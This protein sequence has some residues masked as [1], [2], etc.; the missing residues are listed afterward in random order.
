MELLCRL[1]LKTDQGPWSDLVNV[2]SDRM[3]YAGLRTADTDVEIGVAVIRAMVKSGKRTLNGDELRAEVER[4]GLGS[5]ASY[6]TLVVEAIDRAPWSDAGQVRIDL[7][8]LFA[9][10]EPRASAA[11]RS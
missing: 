6:S 9:G 3:G 4:R 10:D 5:D 8:D 1:G 2:A 7:V 11:S